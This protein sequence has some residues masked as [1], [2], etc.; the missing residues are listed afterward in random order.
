MKTLNVYYKNKEN[1]LNFIDKNKIQDTS[2]LL[3]Q[4]FTSQSDFFFIQNILEIL[5]STLPSA[6]II[7][8]T[9]DGEIKDAQ[10]TTDTTV[11]SFTL[12]E[13]TTLHTFY[14]HHKDR[15]FLS[16]KKIAKQLIHENTKALITFATCYNTSGEEYL[17]GIQYINKDILIAGGIAA[18]NK[19]STQTYVFT[20][21]KIIEDGAVAVALEGENLLAYND[22]SYNWSPIGLELTIENVIDN[23]VYTIDG[24]SAYDTYVHYLGD[25]IAKNL[26]RSGTEFPLIIKRDNFLISRAV[27]Q[28]HEDGSLSFAGDFA[29][30]DKVQFGYGDIKSI[31]KNS[32]NIAKHILQH[33]TEVI[34]IYSCL[35]R[36]HYL[37]QDIENEIQPL[38]NIA[39]TAGF[40]THGE[41]YSEKNKEFLNQ[42]MTILTLSEHKKNKK[43]MLH[44]IEKQFSH[45]AI[46]IN[47]LAHFINILSYEFDTQKKELLSQK[48]LF[49]NLFEKSADGILILKD[50]YFIRCNEMAYKSL[51]YH[52]KS[53][54]LH[55][56]PSDISPKYQPD[57]EASLEKSK[58]MMQIAMKNGIH[59]FEWV[60]LKAD[61]TP[62][63]FEVRLSP[64][65]LD[66]NSYIYATWRD[67]Q[68]KKEM[69]EKLLLQQ[70]EL[71]L[72]ANH[73]KLTGLANRNLF[74]DRLKQAIN[75]AK[76]ANTKIALFFIDLDMF[77]DVNDTLGHDVGDLLLQEVAK[78]LQ[79]EV[80][81]EDTVARIGGDEFIIIMENISTIQ[82]VSKKANI[83][84]KRI[85]QEYTIQHHLLHISCSIG[86]SIFP[87][88]ASNI[89][90]LIKYADTAM[91][92]AKS[93][94][95]NRWWFYSSEMT[96]VIERRMQLDNDLRKAL[97]NNEFEA[98]YQP[99]IDAK[100]NKIIG[101]EAFIR[102]NHPHKGMISP[103]DFIY[104]A[105][106]SD[107]IIE[108]DEW[109]MHTTM[110]K[111]SQLYQEG[112][113][114]GILSLNLT[115]KQ[116][117]SPHFLQ[118]LKSIMKAHNFKPQWLKL[119]ILERQV[120]KKAKENIQKLNQVKALGVRLVMDDFGTGESSFT[121]LTQFPI[122][123]IKIDKS[124]I[125]NMQ[126]DNK[127]IIKAIIALGRALNLEVIAEGV[128]ALQDKE[129]LIENNC[130]L[131]QG[132]Y[133]TKPLNDNDFKNFLKN[134]LS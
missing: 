61:G 60:H 22:Y 3:I 109:M 90:N 54:L 29:I 25:D 30:N 5:T 6:H 78:R 39:P 99:F 23:R 21:E 34:F 51:G 66:N 50:G 11:I 43:V 96:Q 9:T 38:K 129:Y 124:F 94:G 19:T 112:F 37:N 28:K 32:I 47:A 40:F 80:R 48:N 81:K 75:K 4:I 120:I 8:A 76:R 59:Q 86:I 101:A 67:I 116:L 113:N 36:R 26:P 82:Q 12:F 24:R 69:E 89:H 20:H 10:V 49:E 126:T 115:V 1:L 93:E 15:G 104:V 44:P 58:K 88:D 92:K 71:Y 63:W 123:Q 95:R 117:E 27:T 64:I 127:E 74:Y 77:K 14:V 7:G 79:K 52:S 110:Q 119:E 72:Q 31:H 85:L 118:R 17:H 68:H 65:Q 18:H 84:L 111:F 133:F 98:Y 83:L 57:G 114:P 102:W 121:Y 35:A 103:D 16:G 100:E 55:L 97:L 2:S 131:M 70:K 130:H 41:F 125:S 108:L 53:E 13:K 132:Y 91:Y 73:D 46:S 128:E 122:S 45:Q 42:T 134:F 105:Q 87:D 33:P 106:E 56:R 62:C 107:L